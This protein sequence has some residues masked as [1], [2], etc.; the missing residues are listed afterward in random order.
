MF[1]V[2]GYLR[3]MVDSQASP[4]VITIE[5]Q[6]ILVIYGLDRR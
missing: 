6:D 3:V 1:V 2:F 5:E 4:K